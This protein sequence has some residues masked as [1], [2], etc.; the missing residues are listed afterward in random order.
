MAI[1]DTTIG[2]CSNHLIFFYNLNDNTEKEYNIK[3]NFYYIGKYLIFLGSCF[4]IAK[5]HGSE[6]QTPIGSKNKNNY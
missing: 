5:I 2:Y 4:Y 1:S 3:P 6:K